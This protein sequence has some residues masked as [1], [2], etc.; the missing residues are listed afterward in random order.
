MKKIFTVF[1]ILQV[2]ATLFTNKAAAQ[3]IPVGTLLL[4]DYYRRMQLLGE[5]DSNISFTVRPLFPAVSSE[6]NDMFDPDTQLEQNNWVRAKPVSFAKRHGFFHILP[7]TWQQ[8]YNSHHPYGWN[9]GAMIPAKGYQTM[10]SGGFFFKYGPLS[11]QFRPEYV[12]AANQNFN[13]YASGHDELD[14]KYYYSFHNLIDDPERHGIG[15][16]KKA[17][18]GQSSI[19]LTFGP[20]SAGLS[21]ESL[22]WG[23]GI[24]N[25][26]I[27]SNNAPGFKHLTLNTIR[28]VKTFLGHFEGQIIG[29]RLEGSGLSPLTTNALQDGTNLF[30][31]KP[32]DWRYFTGYNIN[33]HPRWIP[34]LTLGMART[35][36]AYKKDV[37]GFGGYLPFFTPFAKAATN[38]ADGVPQGDPY[39]R[40][41]LTSFYARWLFAKAQAEIYFEYGLGDNSYNVR[42]FIGAPDHSR[43]YVFG[44]RKMIPVNSSFGGHI[45]IGGEITQLSQ[46]AERSIREQGLLYIHSAVRDGHTH[47][48]QVLGAGTGPGGNIQSAEVSWVSKLKRIGV[49]FE[50]YEHDVDF[51][52]AFLPDL[53]SGSRRWV[54]LVMALE[55]EWTYKNVLFSGKIQGVQSLN[56]QWILNNY[57]PGQYYVPN[58]S[59]YNLHAQ[60]GMTFRF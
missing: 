8:Q 27:L 37:Q 58:N 55:G 28:P 12:Y 19:R 30:N 35:F 33:Y 1:I 39:P 7:L 22:W 49:S 44:L 16:Y 17:F 15:P 43:G 29:G 31:A 51:Q 24:K 50:R 25:A 9:D 52:Q 53:S 46:H 10:I 57:A 34:G 3:T 36:N 18:W 13:G 2:S 42:D 32:D 38:D 41:Q 26:L 11:I 40:D 23:P 6:G 47:L 48:G 4:N 21:N 60:L 56:Y 59:V 20:I 5:V 54:D 14:L 45:L